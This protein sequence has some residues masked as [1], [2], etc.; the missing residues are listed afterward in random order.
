MNRIVTT[1]AG[2]LPRPPEV[3]ALVEGR[4]QRQ[5]L[6]Q[7]GAAELIAGAVQSTVE[8]QR[9]IGIDIPSD[10]E[11][12]RVS[13]SAYATERLTG[14]DGTPQSMGPTVE[15]GMFPEFYAAVPAGPGRGMQWPSC[16]APITWRGPEFVQRDIAT[17]KAVAPTD[18]FMTA[19]SPG[20]IWLNFRNEHYASD[21]EYVLA[22]ARALG[23]EYRAI[24]DA[25]LLLQIDDPG[26]AWAGTAAS[27]P[28][29]RSTTIA[30]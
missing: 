26:L 3:L 13:F 5:V 16:N 10:G 18:A 19:V 8:R 29:R 9:Q 23:N 15:R 28:T 1:H 12:G 22:A 24:V 7:P 20:Q 6:A 2:S 14:F 21:Q 27:S 11:M 30:R 17:F 25:G 4:D